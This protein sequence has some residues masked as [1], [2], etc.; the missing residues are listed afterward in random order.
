MAGTEPAGWASPA[1]GAHGGPCVQSDG[2]EHPGGRGLRASRS[3]DGVSDHGRPA[4]PLLDLFS[5]PNVAGVLTCASQPAVCRGC[6]GWL[7]AGLFQRTALARLGS[8]LR[9]ALRSGGYRCKHSSQL[10]QYVVLGLE[11]RPSVCGCAGCPAGPLSWRLWGAHQLQCVVPPLPH[12]GVTLGLESWPLHLRGVG[13]Q[14]GDI[15]RADHR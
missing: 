9:R 1:G 11:H 7:P 5:F 4:S 2:R 13:C 3:K 6:R 12:S 15:G 8:D 10:A 14:C